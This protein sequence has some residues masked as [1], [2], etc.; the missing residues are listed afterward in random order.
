MAKPEKI[1]RITITDEMIV[2]G[3]RKAHEERSKAMF[4]MLGTVSRSISSIFSA[5]GR[6]GSAGLPHAT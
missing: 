4:R 1:R 3:M 5:P 6:S 2:A